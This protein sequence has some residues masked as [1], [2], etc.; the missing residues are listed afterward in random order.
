MFDAEISGIDIE[1]TNGNKV[2]DCGVDVRVAND[3]AHHEKLLTQ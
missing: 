3:V 1:E 2:F